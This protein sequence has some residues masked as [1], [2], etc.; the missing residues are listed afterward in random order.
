MCRRWSKACRW[1]DAKSGTVKFLPY[2]MPGRAGKLDHRPGTGLIFGGNFRAGLSLAT[3]D[4]SSRPEET[5]LLIEAR[6]KR[7]VKFSDRRCLTSEPP[8]SSLLLSEGGKYVAVTGDSRHWNHNL[9]VDLASIF[10]QVEVKEVDCMLASS[11]SL[12]DRWTQSA[13]LTI[14]DKRSNQ[15]VSSTFVSGGQHPRIVGL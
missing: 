10:Q 11:R 6:L 9:V 13:V 14:L 7:P 2:K 3:L 8:T 15:I 1:R 4:I 5:P 12:I